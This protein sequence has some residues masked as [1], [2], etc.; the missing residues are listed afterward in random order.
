[1]EVKICNSN[2]RETGQGRL[3]PVAPCSLVDTDRL[4]EE[5]TASIIRVYPLTRPGRATTQKRDILILLVV[6]T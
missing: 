6:R 2:E 5:F 1:M 4:F 3:L